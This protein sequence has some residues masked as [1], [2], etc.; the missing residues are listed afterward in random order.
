MHIESHKK[1]EEKGWKKRNR[2][3]KEDMELKGENGVMWEIKDKQSKI[4]IQHFQTSKQETSFNLPDR[5]DIK[6]SS[7]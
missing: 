1:G 2:K 7:L 4:S 5:A 3:K 6:K